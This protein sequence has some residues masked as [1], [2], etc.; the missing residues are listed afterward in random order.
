MKYSAYTV[1]GKIFGRLGS[2][3]FAFAI[4]ACGIGPFKIVIAL[5]VTWRQPFIPDG[6]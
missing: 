4:L 6:G 2:V 1:P 5:N 3:V